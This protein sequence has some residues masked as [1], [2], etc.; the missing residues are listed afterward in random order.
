MRRVQNVIAA[1]AEPPLAPEIL[2]DGLERAPL[3]AVDEPGAGLL[4]QAS[5]FQ[6]S[7]AQ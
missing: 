3:G 2:D 1:L 4:V 6:V 5:R 7:S